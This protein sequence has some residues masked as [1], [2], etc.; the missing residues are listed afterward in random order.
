MTSMGASQTVCDGHYENSVWKY[1]KGFKDKHNIDLQATVHEAVCS[2]IDNKKGLV[3]NVVPSLVRE[4]YADGAST[5]VWGWTSAWVK[6]ECGFLKIENWVIH[7]AFDA[8]KKK[9]FIK[10]AVKDQA[11]DVTKKL[12]TEEMCLFLKKQAEGFIKVAEGV[13]V[14]YKMWNG[15]VGNVKRKQRF[16]GR[17]EVVVKLLF[18]GYF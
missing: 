15:S 6:K 5:D 2:H 8:N 16:A 9:V 3:D 12:Y 17:V 13:A 1:L 7:V 18:A 4:A 11:D 10:E 14:A